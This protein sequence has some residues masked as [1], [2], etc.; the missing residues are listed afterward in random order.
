ME[1]TQEQIDQVKQAWEQGINDPNKTVVVMN[2]EA[3]KIIP[4]IADYDGDKMIIILPNRKM[5]TEKLEELKA[6]FSHA[7]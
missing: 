5:T 2:F 4:E 7:D 1:F 6:L 3:I